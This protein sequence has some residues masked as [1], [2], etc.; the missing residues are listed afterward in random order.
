MGSLLH[1]GHSLT[2]DLQLKTQKPTHPGDA[3]DGDEEE[4]GDSNKGKTDLDSS[5]NPPASPGI[6]EALAEIDSTGN[7]SPGLS[8]RKSLPNVSLRC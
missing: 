1:P 4:E 5:E 6:K 7:V 2:M 8:Q 3:E